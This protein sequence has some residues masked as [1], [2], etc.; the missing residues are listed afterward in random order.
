MTLLKRTNSFPFF[1][2]FMEDE[3]NRDVFHWPS[4]QM[5]QS[6]PAVNVHETEKAFTIEVAAPGVKK[7]DFKITLDQNI[8]TI[9]SKQENKTEEKDEK[10]YYT[11]R[12]FSYSSF[13][14]SFTLP[15]KL[16]DLDKIEAKH[17]NGILHIVLPKKEAVVQKGNRLIDVN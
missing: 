16:V 5:K 17:E 10:K 8:I 15:D 2:S 6:V 4:N 7:E 1:P 11:R 12:E 14:R 13:S 3:F 9:S